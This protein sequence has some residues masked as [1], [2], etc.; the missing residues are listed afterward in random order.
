MLF[1]WR[2]SSASYFPMRLC[3]LNPKNVAEVAP[4]IL[5]FFSLIV[6]CSVAS[7][8][9]FEITLS[10]KLIPSYFFHIHVTPLCTPMYPFVSNVSLHRKSSNLVSTCDVFCALAVMSPPP[11]FPRFKV[12]QPFAFGES[13]Y[14]FSW[15]LTIHCAITNSIVNWITLVKPPWVS[16]ITFLPYN[17]CIDCM[18]FGQ[19]WTLFC[20][21]NSSV[22]SQ[23]YIIS[24]RQFRD[25]ASGFL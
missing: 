22:P 19:Y 17:C 25:F 11:C 20:L 12:V 5:L 18:E 13:Y 2:T 4:H 15:L 7:R 24:V 21:T 1:C 23:P 9:L 14:G 16:A 8:L 3:I 6:S 10:I